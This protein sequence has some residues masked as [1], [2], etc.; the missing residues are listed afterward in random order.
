[1]SAEPA[2]ELVEPVESELAWRQSSWPA[3]LLPSS[4]LT[5]CLLAALLLP[6]ALAGDALASLPFAVLA[7]IVE[8]W[9]FDSRA[10]RITLLPSAL[11]VGIAAG[12]P[13]VLGAGVTPA[14]AAA[15]FVASSLILMVAAMM[16]AVE[17]RFLRA[18]RRVFLV[19]G[20]D[21]LRDVRQEI[22][23]HAGM[24]LV[25]FANG[26][27]PDLASRI[28]ASGATM[29]VLSRQAADDAAVVSA[30][31]AFN[32]AGGRVRDLGSFYERHFGKLP[33]SELTASWFLFDIAE[34]HHARVYGWVKRAGDI[35]CS[36]AGLVLAAPLLLAA[37][38]AVR[39]TS[40]GPVLYRQQRVGKG[41]R[42]FTLLKFRTMTVAGDTAAAWAD[43]HA[44]RVT[45][46]GRVLRRYRL[47]EL[48]QLWTILRGD[49]SLVG[50]R[51]EQV[52]L[53]AQLS[54]TIPFYDARH[55]VR[56]GLTGWAQVRSGYGGSHAGTL[57]K[58]QYDFFYI[59]HQS[60]RLDLM[61]LARTAHAVL[62]GEG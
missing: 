45:R 29:L 52:A 7:L 50:P 17:V 28:E 47:D 49:M 41:Q 61:I 16:R 62:R 9:M 53:A 56:P 22:A 12:A 18:S 58:L 27:A 11:G 60:L 38:V 6:A 59:R 43:G 5:L 24:T 46:V 19:A 8:R 39:A 20:A 1:M 3:T 15:A 36:A 21:Q 14:G 57:T 2:I 26:G 55:V 10:V 25:G 44:H 48:P 33:L 13:A 32:L 31:S 30:A 35:A 42:P 34:I 40:P 51:P 37:A 54:E 4:V 23:R